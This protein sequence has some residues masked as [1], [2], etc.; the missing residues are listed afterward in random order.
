MH[1]IAASHSNLS[2]FITPDIIC[3][4]ID[5]IVGMQN[6]SF[7]SENSDDN[8]P[9]QLRIIPNKV[10]MATGEKY[11]G[12]EGR[13]RTQRKYRASTS[14]VVNCSILCIVYRTLYVF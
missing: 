10:K 4:I 6:A 12:D 11:Y 9:S 5:F 7:W 1:F 2:P 14:S 8:A 3:F 13:N